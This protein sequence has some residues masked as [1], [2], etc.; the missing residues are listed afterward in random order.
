VG[1]NT[2]RSIGQPA[3]SEGKAY[4]LGLTAQQLRVPLTTLQLQLQ[5]LTRS[6][7]RTPT[8]P[9]AQVAQKLELLSHQAWRLSEIV[10][11]TDDLARVLQG[12]LFNDI[13]PQP[14]ELK[15]LVQTAL[16]RMGDQ[17]REQGCELT[18]EGST[19]VWGEWDPARVQ[20]VLI[21]L[22]QNALAYA[23]RNPIQVAIQGGD[24]HALIEVRDYGT[25]IKDADLARLE[26]QLRVPPRTQSGA[27]VGLWLASHIALALGGTLVGERCSPGSRFRL[28]LGRVKM[29]EGGS[30]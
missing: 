26:P 3:N 16:A 10:E 19:A 7:K 30:S 6:A 21:A 27:G 5:L 23:A 9:S 12:E 25:G 17:A 11:A 28:T 18:F 14:V 2:L 1:H 20:R 29:G 4:L 8:L 22:V 13:R 24:G 15:Q